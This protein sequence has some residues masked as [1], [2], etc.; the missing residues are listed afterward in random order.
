MSLPLPQKYSAPQ[1]DGAVVRRLPSWQE[2]LLV[3]GAYFLIA[4]VF[5]AAGIN[6]LRVLLG[7]GDGFISGLPT[8]LFATHL[9]AWNPYVQLGQYAFAITQY[10]PFYPPGL[11][12]MLLFHNTLGYNLF[13]LSHYAAAGLFF[14]LFAMNLRLV[15][16]AGFTGGLLFMLGGFLSMHG[17]HHAMMS[18]AIW[19]PLVLLFI[20]RYAEKPRLRELA[21][22]SLALAAAILAGFPQ[23]TVYG[24][25]VVVAYTVFRFAS[26]RSGWKTVL[27]ASVFTLTAVTTLSV[28]LSSLQ[29]FAV[30]EILPSMTR[31]A[32]T[33]SMFTEDYLP[34]YEL[35]CFVFPG[36]MG[37]VNHVPTYA[38]NQNLVE[39]YPYMGLLPLALCFL[40]VRCRRKCRDASFWIVVAVA[41]LVLSFGGLTPLYRILYY[42]PVYNLF[43]APARH[44]YEIHFAM[45][46]LSALALDYLWRDATRQTVRQIKAAARFLAV[47]FAAVFGLAQVLRVFAGWLSFPQSK[48]FDEVQVNPLYTV[49]ALK[50]YVI[51]NLSP[52][53]PTI[54]Y[55]CIFFVLTLIGLRL[56]TIQ[57]CRKVALV[58]LAVVLCA[59]IYAPYSTMVGY[60]DTSAVSNWRAR[61]ELVFLEGR[62]FDKERYR[63]YP[64]NSELV[65]AYPLLNMT[66]GISAINDYCPMWSKRYVALTDFYLNGGMPATNLE[67]SNVL[68][69]A[70]AQ[71]LLVTDKGIG[72]QLT[73]AT[74]TAGTLAQIVTN[75]PMTMDHAVSGPDGVYTLHSPDGNIVSLLQCPLR[76]KK[77]TSYQISF[78]VQPSAPLDKPLVVNLYGAEYDKA[79]QYRYLGSL[80]PGVSHQKFSINSGDY[81][82]SQGWVRIYTQAR[83]HIAVKD[84]QVGELISNDVPGSQSRKLYRQVYS[85]PDGI[86]VFENLR[87]QPRFRFVTS[88]R[89]CKDVREAREIL[90]GDPTF[91]VASEALVE[92]LLAPTTVAPGEI[93]N[94]KLANGSMEWSVKTGDRSF[95]VVAD[96]WSPGWK[97]EVDGKETSIRVVDG[98][99]RGVMIEGAGTHKL[100]MSF[101]PWSVPTGLFATLSALGLIA[102]IYLRGDRYNAKLP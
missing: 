91:D 32:L 96:S 31:E 52:E 13:I 62:G 93:L 29:L 6:L 41:A 95:F 63:I 66:Y 84:I 33:Y 81:A 1:Q 97:A 23:V 47:V 65:Y 80:S 46:V 67:N 49:G 40:A 60:T 37:G 17:G 69:A 77:S 2:G 44:L 20:D 99:L 82:P 7:A 90:Y 101:H 102:F 78:T 26:L 43:R 4:L 14:Y 68:S 58:V 3:F 34:P 39:L 85:T 98:F 27:R 22:A 56:L 87:V 51:E 10:Q 19:L 15:R 38:T 24:M 53:H 88:L 28:L 89:R 76:L 50:S 11:V 55:P 45:A 42:V 71:Y 72:D 94:Y 73:Q 5:H 12:I 83:V 25:M 57:R 70:S 64:V 75:P 36:M 79:P 48:I 92:G 16:Y 54:L 35:L 18:A 61:P 100:E 21:W 59:D 74:R 8:K 30:A 86:S 9:Y